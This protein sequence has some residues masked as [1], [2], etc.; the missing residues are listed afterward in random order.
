MLKVET[1]MMVGEQLEVKREELM[2]EV[3]REVKGK[4]KVEVKEETRTEVDL[5]EMKEQVMDLE[6]MKWEEGKEEWMM[7]L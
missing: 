5:M 1:R 6:A 7:E 4:E 2:M 3:E